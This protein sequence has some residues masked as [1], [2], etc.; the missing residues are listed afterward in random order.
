MITIG[1]GIIGLIIAIEVATSI[2]RIEKTQKE[3]NENLKEIIKRID[4]GE[5]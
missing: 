1:G 4:N 5:V 2:I 3:I